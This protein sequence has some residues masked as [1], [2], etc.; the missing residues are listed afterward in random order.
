[1]WERQ[2]HKGKEKD[3]L[4]QAKL[5]LQNPGLVCS[6]NRVELTAGSYLSL[7]S[8]PIPSLKSLFI[9]LLKESTLTL[10]DSLAICQKP[11]LPLRDFRGEVHI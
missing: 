8:S 6:R 3:S 7:T 10:S 2:G 5:N 9:N 1:M 4:N 11:V